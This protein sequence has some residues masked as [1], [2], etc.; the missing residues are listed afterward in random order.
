MPPL[1]H[2]LVVYLRKNLKQLKTIIFKFPDIHFPAVFFQLS[3]PI[4]TIKPFNE[5]SISWISY[6][7]VREKYNIR[8]KIKI[9]PIV[10]LLLSKSGLSKLRKSHAK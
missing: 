1:V 7:A 4:S 10:L 5:K 8:T 2:S 3:R 9:K 6:I